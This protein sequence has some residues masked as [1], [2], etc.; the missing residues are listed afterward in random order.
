MLSSMSQTLIKWRLREVMAR[1]RIKAKDLAK[2]LK[3]SANA[4]SNLRQSETMPR[5]DGDSLNRLCNALNTLAKGLDREITPATLI[6]YVWDRPSGDKFS[7]V[8]S[9]N[10]EVTQPAKQ[11]NRS[12]KDKFSSSIAL[13]AESL[14]SA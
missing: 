13:I 5:L 11:R 10:L 14:E 12:I 4:I 9:P 1:Y 3:L 6:D 7:S 8:N 2:E